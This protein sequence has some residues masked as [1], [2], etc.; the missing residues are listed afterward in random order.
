MDGTGKPR[1]F[2]SVVSVWR[3]IALL[4]I[5]WAAPPLIARTARAVSW[6]D[7]RKRECQHLQTRVQELLQEEFPEATVDSPTTPFSWFTDPEL[8]AALVTPTVFAY[9]IPEGPVRKKDLEY[10]A[11]YGGVVGAVD[12]RVYTH[13]PPPVSPDEIIVKEG[14]ISMR[15]VRN[16]RCGR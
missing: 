15:G 8:A 13:D 10:V 14:T 4:L 6:R 9:V 7:R 12:L 11:R 16:C 2:R 1:M 3:W 5:A